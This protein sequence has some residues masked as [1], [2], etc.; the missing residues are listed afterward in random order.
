[1]VDPSQLPK[2]L[3]MHGI[4]PEMAADISKAFWSIGLGEPE[5]GHWGGAAA[6]REHIPRWVAEDAGWD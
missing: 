6:W 1:R 2:A 5:P 3:A 4:A